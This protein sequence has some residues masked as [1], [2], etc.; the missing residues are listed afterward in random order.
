MKKINNNKS[1]AIH[2][3]RG[4]V[5][6]KTFG[7]LFFIILF[8][9]ATVM[10][11]AL[12]FN[13]KKEASAYTSGATPATLGSLTFSDYA[14]RTD[15]NIFDGD[16]LKKLYGAIASKSTATYAEA[17]AAVK[18]SVSSVTGSASTGNTITQ[19]Q[20]M[21]FAKLKSNA[22]GGKTSGNAITVNF[23]G[24]KWNVVYATVSNGD[25]VVTLWQSENSTQTYK[26]NTYSSLDT[27][28][29]Y[30]S[31]MY[32]TSYIR[33]VA[34]NGGAPSGATS[35]ATSNT[36]L[37]GTVTEANRKTNQY[38]AFTLD[39]ATI[40]QK[41]LTSY[42]VKPNQIAYQEK[43]NWVWSYCGVGNP[44][45]LPSEAWGSPDTS[46]RHTSANKTGGWYPGGT[47]LSNMT[48]M[49]LKSN[50]N[51]WANDTLWLPSLTET[52]FYNSSTSYGASLWGIPNGDAILKSSGNTWSRSG[53]YDSATYCNG[54]TS[55]GAFFHDTTT[56]SECVRPAL[57]LNLKAAAD[58]AAESVQKPQNVHVPY[59][60]LPQTIAMI[61]VADR[62]AWYDADLYSDPGKVSVSYSPVNPTAA[63]DYTATYTLLSTEYKWS[64]STSFTSDRS[65]D[66]TF[67]IDPKAIEVVVVD[68]DSDGIPDHVNCDP[69]Q[70]CMSDAP[71]NFQIIYGNTIGASDFSSVPTTQGSYY[72]TAVITDSNSNYEIDTTK[73]QYYMQFSVRGAVTK[74]YFV[75]EA[76]D[77]TVYAETAKYNGS[78]LVFSVNG[79]NSGVK[80]VSASANLTVNGS[81]LVVSGG[82]GTY[83]ATVSLTD[84]STTQWADGGNQS[85]SLEITVTKGDYD[86]S[87]VK[88]QYKSGG[89]WVDFPADGVT[90][91]GSNIEMRVTGLPAG[92]TVLTYSGTGNK[93]AGDYTAKVVSLSGMDAANYNPVVEANVTEF[94]LNYQINKVKVDVSGW[95]NETKSIS[96]YSVSV[97]TLP[98]N[99]A[100]EV[101]YYRE[102]DWDFTNNV[103]NAGATGL[104]A[105]QI[106]YNPTEAE[107]YYAYAT[108][109]LNATYQANYELSGPVAQSFSVGGGKSPVTVDVPVT[110]KTYDGSAFVAQA[111]ATDES[112]SPI[113]LDLVYTYYA[114]DGTTPLATA[115]STAGDYFVKVAIGSAN[116]DDY[117]ISGTSTFAFTID[118]AQYNL[119]GVQ[120]KVGSDYYDLSDTISYV[121]DGTVRTITLSGLSDVVGGLSVTL[122]GVTSTKNAG[123]HTVTLN[124]TQDSVNY[125]PCA[126]PATFNWAITK[127]SVDLSG[128]GWNYSEPF[129]YTCD[130]NGPVEFSV[131]PVLPEGVPDELVA[132]IEGCLGGTYKQTSKGTYVATASVQ[133]TLQSD[134]DVQN[135]YTIL[136]PTDFPASLN[137]KIGEREFEAPEFDGSWTI[138][139]NQAHDLAAM[140]GLPSDWANYFDIEVIFTLPDGTV[141]SDYEGYEGD[142]NKAF[143]AGKYEITFSVKSSVNTS[144]DYNVWLGDDD[145]ATVIF[146]IAPRTIT[147]KSWK[148]SGTKAQPQ[149]TDSD[150]LT[151][152]YDYVIYDENKNPAVPDGSGKLPAGNYSRTIEPATQNVEIMFADMQ[153][154]AF[155]VNADGSEEVIEVVKLDRPVF[156]GGLY[157]SGK[158]V[159]INESNVNAYFSGYDPATMK[160]VSSETGRNAGDYTVTF[161]LVDTMRYAW[162]SAAEPLSSKGGSSV[163]VGLGAV[164]VLAASSDEVDVDYTI[165]KAQ[166]KGEWT[167]NNGVPTIQVPAQY[168]GLVGFDYSYVDANGLA[169]SQENLVKGE[170]YTV[171]AVL[172]SDYLNNF[173]FIDENG[174][175]MPSAVPVE[176]S[177]E[178][179]PQVGFFEQ[180]WLFGLA[181]W[182]W[183]IIFAL[184][185]VLLITLIICLVRRSKKR[186][187]QKIILEQEKERKE[188]EARLREEEKRRKE[189]E[190]EEEKRRREEERDEERRR[191]EEE[192]EEE[193]RRREEEREEERRR[194]E[195]ERRIAA[196]TNGGGFGGGGLGGL[197]MG[198]NGMAMGFGGMMP[199]M[200]MQSMPQQQPMMQ[201]PV[202]AADNTMTDEKLEKL[203]AEIREDLKNE[204]GQKD[205][206]EQVLESIAS[207]RASDV[208]ALIQDER[209]F[210]IRRQDYENRR[211]EAEQEMSAHRKDWQGEINFQRYEM[212]KSNLQSAQED[213]IRRLE[214][215]VHELENSRYAAPEQ[216]PAPQPQPAPVPVPVPMP[217]PQ[218]VPAYAQPVYA[219]PVYAQP[220]YAQPMAQPAQQTYAQPMYAQPMQQPVYPQQM[221]QP[222]YGQP[223]YGDD[224]IRELEGKLHGLEENQRELV[225]RQEDERRFRDMEDRFSVKFG[226]QQQGYMPQYVMPVQQQPQ[227]QPMQQPV[228]VVQPQQPVVQPV[229][230]PVM[231][232]VAQP[233][234]RKP[235]IVREKA[236]APQPVAQPV[237]TNNAP[238]AYPPAGTVMTTTTTTTIDATKNAKRED[239]GFSNN[240]ESR[241]T[242]DGKYN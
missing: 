35:Y 167:V 229:V 143:D 36:Q 166:L 37:G 21:N 236:P 140:C 75:N 129:T 115:P 34:V 234:S 171:F 159:V 165:L 103:P 150:V 146:E 174:N 230:Q 152:W 69:T 136:Y 197:G 127:C 27:A 195:D 189:E 99:P 70:M 132:L 91:T 228:V 205:R 107:T 98:S 178:Y 158:D 101:V 224:R 3:I 128:I 182:M 212:P 73:T 218:P 198:A 11:L 93:N 7:L 186:K 89:A 194:R 153:Y 193:R 192:R 180:T 220:M 219:Q 139:D 116:S 82:V 191:K 114:S 162:K 122:S 181:M 25:L 131:A 207:S 59:T 155:T 10:N 12:L 239:F 160:I 13:E 147:V 123:N 196:M 31:S 8:V 84:P 19:S 74:P 39:N 164:V 81:Y 231:K 61:P 24:F 63:G 237:V 23:G 134:A 156:V 130:E 5:S 28:N 85:Y 72:A 227:Q 242:T 177:F 145:T 71:P 238:Q 184:I 52:G 67:T 144:A 125:E 46:T 42:L 102:S 6:A 47:N 88:W 32:S 119:S 204:L 26:W 233:V 112:G 41:S 78:N 149:F 64:D 33:A 169:V 175:P 20:S 60:G 86:F 223:F 157:Y 113:G 138:F 51:D 190:R 201:Q 109:N 44:Y 185:A 240:L 62:P 154:I 55:S 111:E 137:W 200:G 53:E 118:K 96:G 172:G 221:Q 100:Y 1:N 57:H 80:M 76:G 120:W 87:N 16:I 179:T 202:A 163:A 65:R 49:P 108:L 66:I 18:S 183:L 9:I 48:L 225:R 188:E 79:I 210:N 2:A 133:G 110:S 124:I 29:A 95:L 213:K 214:R 90:Y 121:Y 208:E 161:G 170:R 54:L 141:V 226:A 4:R 173:E 30:P 126:L 151:D 232:P 106:S 92:L 105:S 211:M 40:G 77:D 176:A 68:S 206:Y 199:A 58:N 235:I 56:T 148:G 203:R 104:A 45:L 215:K 17:L 241:D 217:A 135:N 14:T 168:N 50:Y 117:A 43:E 83:K 97:P 222:M 15:G 94:T 187:A 216:Q 38:A 209:E 142:L 22:G